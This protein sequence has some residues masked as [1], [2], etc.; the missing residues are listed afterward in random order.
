[1]IC[2]LVL[3]AVCGGAE[4]ARAQTQGGPTGGSEVVAVIK[5]K[6]KITLQEVDEQIGLELQSLQ[7]RITSLRKRALNNLITKSL[8]EDEAQ[9][10][11]VTVEELRKRLVPEHV[12]VAQAEV[13]KIY[14]ANATRF[15]SLSEDEAK[16]RIKMD[17]ENRAKFEAFQKALAKLRSD[18]GVEVLLPEPAG[19][20]LRASTAGP[21]A[22][23]PAA[24]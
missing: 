18:A 20:V 2:G 3:T 22:R 17:L 4:A 10:K 21:S 16:Q 12:E 6:K 13:D 23:R 11:G 9:A 19:P 7:E 1:L 24:R 5:G 14:A 8:L 15:A